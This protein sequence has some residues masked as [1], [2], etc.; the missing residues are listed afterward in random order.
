MQ[1]ISA[2]LLPLFSSSLRMKGRDRE[3]V[4]GEGEVVEDGEEKT[5]QRWRDTEKE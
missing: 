5:M 1:S 2:L 4:R 3:Q